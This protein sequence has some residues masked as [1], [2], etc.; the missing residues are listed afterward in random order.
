MSGIDL[1][2]CNLSLWRLAPGIGAFPRR[3]AAGLRRGEQDYSR[4]ARAPRSPFLVTS[5]GSGSGRAYIAGKPLSS[6]PRMTTMTAA[7]PPV[8]DDLGALPEW[9]LRDLYPG[10]DSPALQAD[11]RK[12]LE[13]A[14]AFR[15]RFQG[16]LAQIDGAALGQAV[17]SYESI[18]ELLGR[19]MSY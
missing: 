11:L 13:D 6:E 8:R 16:K 5:L 10:R 19:I 3:I 2:Q 7:T 15:L 9:N 18:Q 12:A 17:A 1:C 14:K 4:Q